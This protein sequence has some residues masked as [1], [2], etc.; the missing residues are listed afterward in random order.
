MKRIGKR[1][2]TLVELLVVIG[3]IALLISIL[4]P[5]LGK[6][7]A[8]ASKV[9]CSAQLRNL[10]QAFLMY[11]NSN[12]GKMPQHPADGQQW[13]WDLSSGTRDALL[14]YGAIRESFYCPVFPEQNIDGAWNFR[15][16]FA[17]M[18]YYFLTTRLDAAGKPM[19]I[20][21]AA[22]QF[23]S[24]QTSFSKRQYID[25][26]RP[27]FTTTTS[28]LAGYSFQPTKPSDVEVITDAIIRQSSGSNWGADGGLKGHVTSHMDRG[29]PAGT[30]I[31]FLDGH[32]DWRAFKKQAG[33]TGV[34]NGGEVRLRTDISLFQGLQFWF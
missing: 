25:S 10:G 24:L 30:N 15:P 22:G 21:N 17:V 12:R 29:L 7:R 1:G 33:A 28:S 18:G 2:F 8:Q 19:V 9:K 14:R 20:G 3:I 26:L 32:V 34:W 5:A 11:A 23:P 6:A 4:L 16:T 27:K 13:L 31:F